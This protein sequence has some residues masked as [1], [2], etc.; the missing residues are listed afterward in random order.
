M[1]NK[2]ILLIVLL[3]IVSHAITAQKT[4]KTKQFPSVAIGA[5]ILSFNGDVGNGAN[6]SSF[7]RIR[8][9]YNLTIEQRIGK[10]FGLSL[11]GIYGK[12]SDSE[13]SQTK[14]LNF[15]STIM[16]GD[17]NV[18]L[19]FDND[20]V[21]SRNSVFAPYV[22]AGIGYLKFDPHGDLKNKNDS[23]YHYW[24]DGTI[25][26]QDQ[27]SPLAA[28]SNI[29]QRDYTYE[30]QLKD[31]TTSYTRGTLAVPIGVGFNLKVLH[32]LSVNV[33]GTY[34][35]AFSDWIDNVK[36]G[37][38]D[39]Y[40]FANVSVQYTFGKEHDDSNPV[41]NGVDFSALEKLDT[42]EDGVNDN[43]DRCPGTP[44]SVKVNGRGC[45]EDNDE[46]G[47]P[48][49]KDKELMTKKDALVDENGITITDKML[50]DKQSQYDSLATERSEL[51]NENP[52]LS[53]LRDVEAK[54][55]EARK[56][57][58]NAASTIPYALRPADTDKNGY[59]STAEI[60]AAI[61]KFFE[62]D[63]DFSVEKLNDLIDFFF[64]Q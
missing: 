58:P 56:A 6:L 26:D 37:G 42:D 39:R 62:G 11:N 60:A 47:I 55:T 52:S 27:S 4:E 15:E 38:N 30:T 18:V 48:D 1:R 32:N 29:I 10:Y 54:S 25:H 36:E 24:S 33:G 43:D 14:N 34:Y 3:F 23:T 35:L 17:F 45:P 57:N 5:G 31:S 61:D 46:D 28:T 2:K 53:Y 51:F 16:Q 22:F 19:H 64:E 21:F 13:R 7:S 49:Y 41:Y 59:I 40:F 9:G 50:S 8:A 20:L 44:K 63:S 12:L